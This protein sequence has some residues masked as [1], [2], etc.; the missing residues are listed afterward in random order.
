MLDD[1]AKYQELQQQLETDQNAFATSQQK[2]YE[3]HTNT[4][5]LNQKNHNDF[6]E[7]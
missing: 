6:V 5:N 4:V 3:E 1:A 7:K 2:I